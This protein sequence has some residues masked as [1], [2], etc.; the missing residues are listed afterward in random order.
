MI[1]VFDLDDTVCDTDSYS[2]K[3]ILNYFKENKLPYKKVNN[4]ARFAEKKF[5][6]DLDVA[7][8]WYKEYGDEMMLNF[9]CKEGAIEFI[10]NLYDLGHIIVIATARANDWHKE[11]KKITK[12]WLKNVGLKY[13]KIYIGRIDK[14]QICK[15]ENAD[16][17]IDDDIAIT[18][19]VGDYFKLYNKQ[20][21]C[22]LMNTD[23]NKTLEC[24]ENVIRVEDFDDFKDKLSIQ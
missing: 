1:F 15:E 22:F 6:W 18:K 14:E 10:N 8:N 2:E 24:D 12:Q 21:K 17:F 11:P 16:V 13:H 20:G 9:P 19:N 3:Y 23:Y 4:I 7:L 5:D